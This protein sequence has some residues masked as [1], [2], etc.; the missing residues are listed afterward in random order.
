MIE[1]ERQEYLV[2][3][4]E[5]KGNGSYKRD[6]KTILGQIEGLKSKEDKRW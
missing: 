6:L 2:E 3:H 5:R 4:S 1:E